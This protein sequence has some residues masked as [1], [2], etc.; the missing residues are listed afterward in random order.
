MNAASTLVSFGGDGLSDTEWLGIHEKLARHRGEESRADALLWMM[1]AFR[2]YAF[3]SDDKSQV[4]IGSYRLFEFAVSLE[5]AK[6]YKKSALAP[7]FHGPRNPTHSEVVKDEM[8]ACA[9]NFL[10]LTQFA[11]ELEPLGELGRWVHTV[12]TEV[13]NELVEFVSAY[14]SKLSV[15]T[16]VPD[17]RAALGVYS[18]ALNSLI[19]GT[20][21]TFAADAGRAHAYKVLLH[22]R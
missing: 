1:N 18:R 8:H 20:D 6:H 10:A 22:A 4:V 21:E 5:E 16:E 14:L 12:P 19:S 17:H 7:I 13:P 15:I 11:A 2:R 3:M 9:G